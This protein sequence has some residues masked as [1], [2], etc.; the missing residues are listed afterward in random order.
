[1]K[2]DLESSQAG[3]SLGDVLDAQ[4]NFF[5]QEVSPAGSCSTDHIFQSA[6]IRFERCSALSMQL[7]SLE[8]YR[9]ADGAQA[10]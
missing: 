5:D 10:N 7:R 6:E 3:A 9:L 2:A 4:N 8:P 1:M